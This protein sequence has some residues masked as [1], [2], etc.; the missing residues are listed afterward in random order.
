MT[1]NGEELEMLTSISTGDVTQVSFQ[2]NNPD[3]LFRNPD[4]LIRNPDFLLKNVEFIIK[5][6]RTLEEKLME[7]RKLCNVV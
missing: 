3:F 1:D 2:W 6:Q 5:K 4:L 7:V